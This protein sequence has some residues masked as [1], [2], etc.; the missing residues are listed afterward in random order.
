M[1]IDREFEGLSAMLADGISA[2]AKKE[3]FGT[4]RW[5]LAD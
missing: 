3:D 4:S 2:A 1:L 5:Q